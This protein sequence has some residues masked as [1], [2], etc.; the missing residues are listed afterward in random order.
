MGDNKKIT[1]PL[2]EILAAFSITRQTFYGLN[3]KYE[4]FSREK[5]GHYSA[6]IR[7][8]KEIKEYY[9]KRSK[10]GNVWTRSET[11]ADR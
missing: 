11:K 1:L 4:V 2:A 7:A 6:K 5:Q 3:R 10:S 9:E 8:F